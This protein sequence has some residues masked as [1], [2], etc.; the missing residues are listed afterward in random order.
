MFKKIIACI[1]WYFIVSQIS[2]RYKPWHLTFSERPDQYIIQATRIFYYFIQNTKY[3]RKFYENCC[4]IRIT[5]RWVYGA[6]GFTQYLWFLRV[7]NMVTL[8]KKNLWKCF[9]FV[10]KSLSSSLY[11]TRSYSIEQNWLASLRHIIGKVIILYINLAK[12]FL[13]YPLNLFLFVNKKLNGLKNTPRLVPRFKVF[14]YHHLTRRWLVSN[15]NKTTRREYPKTYPAP[16]YCTS[17]KGWE[18]IG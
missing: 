2:E 18:S 6:G 16:S 12:C 13:S 17:W 7:I 4:W 1:L 10:M 8:G 14:F 11:C 9:P 15:V 5:L 3:P